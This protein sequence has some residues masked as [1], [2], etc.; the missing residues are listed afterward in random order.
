M[1][2]GAVDWGAPGT[3]KVFRSVEVWA[4]ALAS[5]AQYGDLYYDVDRS[6]SWTL[7]GRAQTSP[8]TTLYFPAGEGTWVSGQSIEL[9]LRSFTASAAYTPVYRSI[10]LRGALR[11]KSVD[12]ISAVV[13]I[14]DNVA[15]REGITM[16][17]GATMLA[18]LRDMAALDSPVRLVDLAGGNA[19]VNVLQPVSEQETYQ[20]GDE[21]PEIAATIKLAVTTFSGA[22]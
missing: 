17:P 9:S 11:P 10:I 3:P 7:L 13:R 15:D 12:I 4:D 21:N 2:L 5:G 19:W 16:R 20:K 22:A 14:A 8:K 1:D 6:G 18:E